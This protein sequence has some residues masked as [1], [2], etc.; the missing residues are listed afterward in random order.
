[1]K[2]KL[3]GIYKRMI[4]R[5]APLQFQLFGLS[6]RRD[7]VDTFHFDLYYHDLIIGL[8]QFRWIT[9]KD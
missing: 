1:M 8:W 5:Y 2:F 6:Y 4:A 3:R 7:H 9:S